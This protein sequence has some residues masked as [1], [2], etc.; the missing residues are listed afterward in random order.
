MNYIYR[1]RNSL[2]IYKNGIFNNYNVYCSQSHIIYYISLIYIF[3]LIY[4]QRLLHEK[5]AN[6]NSQ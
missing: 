1:I 5:G 4:P 3:T 2:N 6:L